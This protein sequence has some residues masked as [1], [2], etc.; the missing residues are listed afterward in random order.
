MHWHAICPSVC[1][2]D[3]AL[4]HTA[5]RRVTLLL[6]ATL[7]L[8]ACSR[9]PVIRQDNYLAYGTPVT[10]LVAGGEAAKVEAA[11]A[12][13]RADFAALHDS[14]HAWKK[15][16]LL[17]EIN[18]AIAAGQPIPIS[19]EAWS[20]LERSRTLANASGHRFEPAIGKLITLWGFHGE[21]FAGP[22]PAA[23]AIARLIRAKPQMSDVL[24]RDGMLHSHNPDVRIDL[25]GIAKGY[26]I[27]RAVTVL[28]A[29]GIDNAIVNTGGDLRAFG[30]HGDRAWSIGVRDPRPQQ[31]P[32][33]RIEI[34]GDESVF[35]SGDYERMFEHAG[36]RYHHILDPQTGWP[37]RGL[38]SVSVIH[39]DAMTADAAATALLVAGPRDW[40]MIA[41]SMGIQYVLAVDEQNRLQMTPRMQERLRNLA[42]QA[43]IEV[44]PLPAPTAH[45]HTAA[46]MQR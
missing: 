9:E 14:W 36:Q 26:A 34:D 16:G 19:A 10:V 25:G 37:A 29:Q 2:A 31:A 21:S 11:F 15:G 28:R 13:I 6:L 20:V 32:I 5:T 44:R 27:D 1:K 38:R 3:A 12:A 30:R 41:A 22:P 7:W 17:A 40:P 18:A 23:E 24:Y 45:A 46:I 4:L 8:T 35:T 43:Q 39:S 33:A 42:P